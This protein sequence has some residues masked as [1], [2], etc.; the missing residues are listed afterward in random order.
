VH[1]EHYPWNGQ[2][3][4]KY[5]AKAIVEHETRDISLSLNAI[6]LLADLNS[7]LPEGQSERW[8]W[9]IFRMDNSGKY[10]F[11]YKYGVPPLAGKSIKYA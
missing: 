5:I 7:C 1:Y 9:L 8:T 6:D 3:I 2:T 4:E 11:D 10:K